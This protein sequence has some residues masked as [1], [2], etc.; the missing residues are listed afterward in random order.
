M[1]RSRSLF[2]ILLF[3]AT[4]G[5]VGLN[6]CG[7]PGAGSPSYTLTGTALNPASVA[8]GGNAT[9]TVTVT[10]ANGPGKGYT[11]SVF[12]SCSSSPG[13][14]AAPICSFSVNPV[15]ISSTAP[16]TSMLRVSTSDNTPG[17]SYTITLTAIDANNLAPSNGAQ[18]LNLT[19]ES[20]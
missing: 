10:P 16:V 6:G 17:D 12:L 11:G 8:A 14:N 2:V 18:R 1:N 13:G 7:A 15:A 4:A 5:F 3:F 9:S 20:P 19:V